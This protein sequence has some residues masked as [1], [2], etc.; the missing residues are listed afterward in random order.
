MAAF[1]VYRSSAGSGK[2]YTLTK[3][4]VKLAIAAPAGGQFFKGDYYQ[5]ILAITF[6]RDAAKEMKERIISSL[7]HLS[8]LEQGSTSPL[9]T[10]LVNEIRQEYPHQE[11]SEEKICQR[12]ALTFTHL[13]HNYSD[14]SVGTIDSFS[15]KV[16]MSFTKDL[17]LPYNYQVE[18]DEEELLELAISR[19]LEQVGMRGDSLLTH[20]IESFA[21]YEASQGRRWQVDKAL[22]EFGRHLFKEQSHPFVEQLAK[23]PLERFSAMHQE[24]SEFCQNL[25]NQIISL[26]SQALHLMEV[27]QILP[28][29]LAGGSKG[30]GTYFSK[31]SQ[32]DWKRFEEGPSKTIYNN[33]HDGK[34]TASAT[35]SKERE[36]IRQ[37]SGQLA[38]IFFQIEELREKFLSDYLEARLALRSL[39]PLGLLGCLRREIELI[40][41]ETNKVHLSELSQ[42][43]HRIIEAEPVPY[44]YERI[45]ER[46][47]HLLIDE[48]QDTSHLQWRNLIPLIVNALGTKSANMVVGDVKQ[49]IYRWRSGDAEIMAHLPELPS[50]YHL[51]QE[52]HIFKH[53]FQPYQLEYNFR[54]AAPIVEFNNQFF[55]YVV[56]N[57]SKEYPD[58]A[59]YYQNHSQ[60]VKKQH[61]GR[62]ELLLL[63]YKE[64]QKALEGDC[65]ED[66]FQLC[67][68]IIDK[69]IA[70]GFKANEIAIICRTNSEAI[71]LAARLLEN[72]Y[73]VVSPESLLVSQSPR[74]Q[75][76]IGFM[77]ILAQPLNPS[78]RSEVLYF[79]YRHLQIDGING[80][81]SGKTHREISEI[82]S[83]PRL[84]D[85]LQFICDRFGKHLIFRALQY[86]SLYEIAEELI[87]IFHLNDNAAEQIF[88]QRLLDELLIFSQNQNNNLDDFI[89]YWDKKADTISVTM[90][91]AG[92]EAIR[93]MT[94][95]SAKGLQFPVVIVPSADWE[96]TPHHQT[97]TWVPWTNQ[98]LASELPAIWVQ[99]SKKMR[100]TAFAHLYEKEKQAAFID[101]I[102]IL[103][104]AMTRAENRLYIISYKRD[105]DK[106]VSKAGDLLAQFVKNNHSL[107]KEEFLNVIRYVLTNEPVPLRRPLLAP[108]VQT[109]VLENFL[110]TESR[111]KL[112]MRRN[113]KGTGENRIDLQTLYQ[114][115]RQGVLLH[116][117]FEKI[118]YM[119][120]LPYAVTALLHEGLITEEEQQSLQKKLTQLL[121]L[122]EIAPLFTLQPKRIV[123]NEKELIA[124]KTVESPSETF[125]PDRI[126]IDPDRIT[127]LDYKTG[128]ELKEKHAQ[129][130]KAYARLITQI[131]AYRQ[132]PV[133]TLL[134]YTEEEKV[135]E[136]F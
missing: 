70:E 15:N 126:V 54:S 80:D 60:K 3:E 33:V 62:V 91:P 120:D 8:R 14:L 67:K 72:G 2:T 88:L 110:S 115:R 134:L 109:Y 75:F 19:L 113:D 50:D 128:M 48:F 82:A 42:R 12:A 122:P 49:A 43:I 84:S 102:N 53:Y 90:P 78:V 87:R 64:D 41:L 118:R 4:F 114:A 52:R 46:Y 51:P 7:Q 6:T 97:Y 30:V 123:L 129:Q 5:R 103:Y 96:L 10:D 35:G 105:V 76:I 111:D 106:K 99:I 98:R 38:E 26:A 69:S 16:A 86:L 95:H 125:R 71:Q 17:N 20:I 65:V 56:K 34:W 100:H 121:H 1:K 13:L 57:F 112:R 92:E 132:R 79:L 130:I 31:L 29:W 9:L 44:L 63:D 73:R 83:N 74:V 24:L 58:L 61:P 21:H 127:I 32:G 89:D 66:N 22:M 40:M 47:R 124:K 23:I 117:A 93:L 37:I 18:L 108:T 81:Y 25:Q 68:E 94:I 27:N 104:V 77:R 136:V 59:R 133:R 28:Q 85:F 36:I 119:E 45:G 101:G 11:W 135:V 131:P 107:K 39:Y 55:D 116:Y